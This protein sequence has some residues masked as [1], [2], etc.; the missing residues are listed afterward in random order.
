MFFANGLEKL[1]QKFDV[2]FVTKM[3]NRTKN[4]RLIFFQLMILKEFRHLENNLVDFL[5]NLKRRFVFHVLKIFY[6][7][8]RIQMNNFAYC[9]FNKINVF[10]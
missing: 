1:N 10:A 5:A 9:V 8:I 4:I 6:E 3:R 2:C 7:I